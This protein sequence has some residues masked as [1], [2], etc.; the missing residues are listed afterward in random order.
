MVYQFGGVF[1]PRGQYQFCHGVRGLV[2][3]CPVTII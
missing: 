2:Y 3:L 1:I